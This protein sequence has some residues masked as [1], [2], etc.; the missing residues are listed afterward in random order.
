MGGSKTTV[1]A[2]SPGPQE[3]A[4][5]ERELGIAERQV[6]VSESAGAAAAASMAQASRFQQE[7]LA[8]TREAM[9]TNA[10]ISREQLD[11]ARGQFGLQKEVFEFGKEQ[12]IAA[13]ELERGRFLREEELFDVSQ[14]LLPVTLEQ[15][16]VRT[17][18]D[19]EGAISGFETFKTPLEEARERVEMAF[20]QRT[21]QALAGELPV[22][23]RV[24]REFD[25]QEGQLEERLLR[26]LGPDFATSTPGM[27][28]LTE[29]GTFKTETLEGIR[30]GRLA[31]SEA[32]ALARAG[33]NINTLF[34]RTSLAS[35]LT[36]PGSVTSLPFA[37]PGAP[38]VSNIGFV[39][40]QSFGG[41]AP[42]ASLAGS[43]FGT[44]AAGLGSAAGTLGGVGGQFAADR[45]MA[46]DAATFNA[47]NRGGGF[48][49]ILGTLAG[50]FAGSLSGGLGLGL[51][52]S[53]FKP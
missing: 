40:Q 14:M 34:Q 31:S 4:I 21:E 53:F 18:F 16:G 8:L 24:L 2:P 11:I 7:Q 6:G 33:S 23:K 52:G 1:T 51:A 30:E 38:G 49:G 32:M 9:E 45:R 35:N 41:G 10:Q 12:S 36:R 15:I 22:P 5:R 19:A 39:P 44:Q 48:G 20:L 50:G 26:S 47:Q 43:L 27:R 29:F 37:A 28:A 3:L 46:L 25:E 13:F 42:F 17:L